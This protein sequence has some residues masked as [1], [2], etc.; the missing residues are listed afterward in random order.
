M[1]RKSKK[2]VWTYEYVQL[3]HFVVQQKLTPHCKATLPQ[4]KRKK[5]SVQ[6]RM[7]SAFM[8]ITFENKCM[9]IYYI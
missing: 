8:Y 3:S 1:G 4:F 2:R 6:E 7:I 9:Y 5:K